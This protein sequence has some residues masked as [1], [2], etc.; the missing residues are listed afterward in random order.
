[1]S[2]AIDPLRIAVIAGTLGRA[3]AEK[4]LVYLVRS[5]RGLPVELR[6]FSLTRD[7]HYEA[8]LEELGCPP[9]WF[10]QRG[11]PALRLT[12]LVRLLRGWQPDVIHSA[13][14]YTNLY[15]GLAGKALGALSVGASRGDPRMELAAN[16]RWGPALARV[17]DGLLCNSHHSAASWAAMGLRAERLQVLPNVIDLQ[18][19]DAQAARPVEAN[20]PGQ[21]RAALVGRLIPV[22]RVDRFLRALA[23]ARRQAPELAGVVI[24]D[25]LER[26]ALEAEAAS[27]GL[28]PDGVRFLGARPEV[29]ALLRQCHILALTSEQE[30]F[31]NALM[32]GM[33]AG[34]PVVSTPA[35]DAER[36]LQ[37][38][39]SGFLIGMD[40]E[41]A[42][43]AR[44]VELARSAALR[45]QMGRAGR[46]RVEQCYQLEGLGAAA[47]SAYRRFAEMRGRARLAAALEVAGGGG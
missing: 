1:M 31:P 15:A 23:A 22:K 37:H 26:A 42:L 24:G 39:I 8:A 44:L 34:L 3:G 47:L 20:L 11:N 4:Q 40:D 30:G 5:L 28:T 25:G 2:R 12:A 10:G 21:V 29:P 36:I 6:V 13:H 46:L 32:E 33:A 17:T 43:A 41:D 18:E 45:E 38:G 16:G 19:F 9:E 27:L 7:E 14:F 35:G